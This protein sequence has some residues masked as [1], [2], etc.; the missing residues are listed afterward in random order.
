LGEGEDAVGR[1]ET[2]DREEGEE[3]RREE[4]SGSLGG[5]SREGI[6]GQFG[7]SMEAM[8]RL[9]KRGKRTLRFEAIA[10]FLENPSFLPVLMRTVGRKAGQRRYRESD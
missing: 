9:T 2:C 4:E 6:E 5:R 1:D 3:E 7:G 10:E 8:G